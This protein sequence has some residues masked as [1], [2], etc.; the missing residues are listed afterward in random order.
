MAKG[1]TGQDRSMMKTKSKTLL[2]VSLLAIGLAAC[3]GDDETAATSGG[4]DGLWTWSSPD[5]WY[6]QSGNGGAAAPQ[7][8]S[9]SASGNATM[10]TRT[11]EVEEVNPVD[12]RVTRRTVTETVPVSQQAQ[13]APSAPVATAYRSP[14]DAALAGASPD[15]VAAAGSGGGTAVA[16]G[17]V[18]PAGK[19]PQS[20]FGSADRQN[21]SYTGGVRGSM[22]GTVSGVGSSGSMSASAAAP[23]AR[24]AM[25]Q[26]AT[27]GVAQA[28]SPDVLLPKDIAARTSVVGG[29]LVTSPAAAAAGRTAGGFD[30]D[31]LDLSGGA[32]ARFEAAPDMTVS[33]R[34]AELETEIV[35]DYDARWSDLEF[36]SGAQ[37]RQQ[38]AAVAPRAASPYMTA[39][40]QPSFGG[41]MSSG[42]AFGQG[43]INLS[44]ADRRRILETAVAYQSR[45]GSVEVIGH[46]ANPASDRMG[47]TAGYDLALARANTVGT[48]LVEAGVPARAIRVLVMGVTGQAKVD[49][50]L[51]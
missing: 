22:G 32:A 26:H 13:A 16:G 42:I 20:G 45:G 12:G 46:A 7:Q 21:A 28:T 10:T 43:S 44:S 17:S 47:S 30:N 31:Y 9:A 27:S 1:E 2:G 51:R 41:A 5:A 37:A 38:Q 4:S 6:E 36:D 49:L 48:A 29:P 14:I 15:Q 50:V 34:M 35:Q 3:A 19:L 8:A 11:Y 33:E 24:V 23:S 25:P 18:I 40:Q 39:P